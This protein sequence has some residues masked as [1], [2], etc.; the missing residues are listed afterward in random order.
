[1]A[2]QGNRDLRLDFLKILA[3]FG[4]VFIHVVNF[5]GAFT[6]TAEHPVQSI[7]LLIMFSLG[8]AMTNV[9]VIVSA[10]MLSERE[11]R[12]K[13]A[14]RLTIKATVY[15]SV[16]YGVLC[17]TGVIDFRVM[18]ALRNVFAIITRQYWFLTAYVVMYLLSPYLNRLLGSLEISEFKTLLWIV[19]GIS[20][21]VPTVFLFFP[22]RSL[23]DPDPGQTFIWFISLYALVYFMKKYHLHIIRARK[24]ALILTI[25]ACVAILVASYFAMSWMSVK[26]GMDGAGCWRLFFNSS[27][28][29]VL[30]SLSIFF[31]T[32]YL[33]ESFGRKSGGIMCSIAST[34][35]GVYL[36][37]SH[38]QLNNLIGNWTRALFELWPGWTVALALASA[39]VIF[40]VTSVIERLVSHVV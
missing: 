35:I 31:L 25:P 19:L 5:G 2:V 18:D 1:M 34:T 33:P 9:F 26:M 13:K 3:M 23:I 40:A 24:K 6:V 29:V 14:I 7:L 11:I 39:L 32:L 22:G 28:P 12:P 38:P 8:Y 30:I 20:S 4:I 10:W 27:I 37:S 21:I 15:A 17:L 36:I 16:I